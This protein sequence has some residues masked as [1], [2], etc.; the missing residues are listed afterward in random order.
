[1]RLEHLRQA[2]LNLLVVFAVLA[3]V[4]S[5]STAAVHLRLSQPA[6][7]RALQRLRS[8]FDDPLW[9][10]TKHRYELTAKGKRVL[11]ELEHILPRLEQLVRSEA[12]DPQTEAAMFRIAGSDYSCSIFAPRLAQRMLAANQVSLEFAPWNPTV[13]QDIEHGRLDLAFHT[14]DGV[15]PAHF[16][17]A[18]LYNE[19]L[20]CVVAHAHP[21]VEAFSR[22]AYVEA[23]HVVVSI[24][25]PPINLIGPVSAMPKP[26]TTV[27]RLDSESGSLSDAPQGVFGS[28]S[29]GSNQLFL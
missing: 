13:L 21:C 15:P 28:W 20:V 26:L 23:A 18:F 5:V 16:K 12:F 19:R 9:V 8:T 6:V 14:Q 25:T 24:L 22:Q 4:G 10:R 2:D 27:P 29:M 17:S 11:A 1:M 3:E 7:S